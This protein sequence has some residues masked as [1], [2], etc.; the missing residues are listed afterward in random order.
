MRVTNYIDDEAFGYVKRVIVTPTVYPRLV[1][2]L[3]ID[4]QN[5]GE[6]TLRQHRLSVLAM[7]CFNWLSFRQPGIRQR[8]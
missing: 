5:T 7:L 2:F 8:K 6:I 3:Q 1:E 4:I